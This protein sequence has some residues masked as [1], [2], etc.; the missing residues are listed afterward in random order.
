MIEFTANDLHQKRQEVYKAALQGPVKITHKFHGDFVMMRADES[1]CLLGGAGPEL[2]GDLGKP[3]I[4]SDGN[5]LEPIGGNKYIVKSADIDRSK[6]GT[7]K[8]NKPYI[9]GESGPEAHGDQFVDVDV[10]VID[11]VGNP[12]IR[13]IDKSSEKLRFDVTTI[14]HPEMDSIIVIKV[15][16]DE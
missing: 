1:Y 4:R 7:I 13:I 14:S 2:Y 3:I 5:I 15:C 10:D 11:I 8:G 16:S 12:K 6:G 9:V